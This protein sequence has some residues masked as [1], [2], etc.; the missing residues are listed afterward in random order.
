MLKL[1]QFFILVTTLLG[2]TVSTY[3]MAGQ[4]QNV[5]CLLCHVMADSADAKDPDKVYSKHKVHHPVGVRYPQDAA[6][7]N[8][9][10]AQNN[11]VS[12]FDTNNN[13]QADADE[14]RFYTVADVSTVTCS[15][16]H[17]EH[18]QSSVKKSGNS[19]LRG[20]MV[21]SELCVACHRK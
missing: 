1:K 10:N 17:R 9:S 18:D 4:E 21:A 13:G 12:F 20:T 11:G 2:V 8:P 15:S 16:C 3:A 19:Y 6:D 5:D 14:V 7:F